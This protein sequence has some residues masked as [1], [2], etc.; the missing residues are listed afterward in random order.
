MVPT[1]P[2]RVAMLAS[3]QSDET[4]REI[5]GVTSRTASSSDR[6]TS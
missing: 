6:A 1:S 4:R 3:D 5:A 2:T